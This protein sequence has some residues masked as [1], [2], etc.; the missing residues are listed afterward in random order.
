MSA[1]DFVVRDDAGLLQRGSLAGADGSS[2]IV[3]QG[4]DVSLNLQRGNILSYVR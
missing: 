1:I 4:Q 2:L 3:A